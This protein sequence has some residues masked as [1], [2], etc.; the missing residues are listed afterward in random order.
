M[1]VIVALLMLIAFGAFI[2]C[3]PK[4]KTPTSEVEIQVEAPDVVYTE[5][6]WH[7]ER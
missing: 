2:S 4:K 1:P 3:A 5:Q 6:L 7:D